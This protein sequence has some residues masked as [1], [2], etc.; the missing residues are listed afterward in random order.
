MNGSEFI[1]SARRL[2]ES[3][4]C[5][6]LRSSV[7]R[8]Y[9]AAYHAALVLI[10]GGGVRFGRTEAHGKMPMCYEQSN[11][12]IATDV[13]RNLNSLRDDRNTAQGNCI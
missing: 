6:D 13:G 4:E 12:P 7:S 2:A 9:Y 5:A 1:E 11:V 10:E 8:S 3:A